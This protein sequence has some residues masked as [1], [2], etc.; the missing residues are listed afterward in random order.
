M[1]V[2]CVTAEC[3][4]KWASTSDARR[5]E[6]RSDQTLQNT[7]GCQASIDSHFLILLLEDLFELFFSY[8]AILF[9]L[10]ESCVDLLVVESFLA[11]A[12]LDDRSILAQSIDDLD[13]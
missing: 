6:E 12:C 10:G 1:R 5:Y 3:G 9:E 7:L 13:S 4:S 2:C 11:E 8:L